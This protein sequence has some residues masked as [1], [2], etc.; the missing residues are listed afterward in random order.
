MLVRFLGTKVVNSQPGSPVNSGHLVT[1]ITRSHGILIPHFVQNLTRFKDFG[2]TTQSLS[3]MRVVV[4]VGGGYVIS[5]EDGE[6][7]IGQP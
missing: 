5:P 2:L 1:R 3:L 6:E 4:N 7:Q